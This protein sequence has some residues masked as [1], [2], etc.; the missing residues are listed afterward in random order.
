MECLNADF[1]EVWA[2]SQNLPLA[3]FATRKRSIASSGLDMLE[4]SPNPA[5]I[6]ELRSFESIVSWYGANRPEFRELVQERGLPFEFLTAIPPE[7]SPTHAADFFVAQVCGQREVQASPRIDCPPAARGHFAVIHPFSSS[8]KKCWPLER[9]RE[10]ARRLKIPVRW[11]AGPEEYLPGAV[12]VDDLY[13]LACWL[14]TARVYIGNDAGITHLAAAVGTPVVAL[15]GPTNPRIWG[16][17]GPRVR[18]IAK[19]ALEDITVEEVL[20]LVELQA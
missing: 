9:Y 4:F 8:P 1:L 6:E 13:Q 2:A 11:C 20:E 19:P 10:L 3:R 18:V 17:R 14:S 16:P 7:N 15:F 5:L 12:H